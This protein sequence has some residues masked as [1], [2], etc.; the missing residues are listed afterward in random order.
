MCKLTVLTMLVLMTVRTI[1]QY[2]DFCGIW[3][4]YVV[5]EKNWRDA[6]LC[7]VHM[8]PLH[9]YFQIPLTLR[10]AWRRAVAAA[11]S[12]TVGR[13]QLPTTGPLQ[14]RQLA[15]SGPVSRYPQ[16]PRGLS[17]CRVFAPSAGRHPSRTR[18]MSAA[19]FTGKTDE[20]NNPAQCAHASSYQ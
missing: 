17:L 15:A 18:A 16:K 8:V 6:Q 19:P 14:L 2:A 12:G 10:T 9:W 11:A 1:V 7:S 3:Q 13:D 20:I 4:R 5:D